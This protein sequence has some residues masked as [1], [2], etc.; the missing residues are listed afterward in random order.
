MIVF[1]E[2]RNF[3]TC[4][5]VEGPWPGGSIGWNIELC[6]KKVSVLI[7]RWSGIKVV[8]DDTEHIGSLVNRQFGRENMSLILKP[9]IPPLNP[10]SGIH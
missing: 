9:Q 6:T 1:K 7:P 10:N 4:L 8:R 5:K 3:T 2:N